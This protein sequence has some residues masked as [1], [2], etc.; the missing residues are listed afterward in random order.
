MKKRLLVFITSLCMIFAYAVPAFAAADKVSD[1]ADVQAAYEAYVAMT[2][3]MYTSGD[4]AAMVAAFNKLDQKSTVIEN[5]DAKS[6]AW[7]T[8]VA[9]KIGEDEFINDVVNL[10]FTMV[11]FEKE[12][13]GEIGL[14]ED[15]KTAPELSKAYD[16]VDMYEALEENKVLM[17][18]LAASIDAADP[19]RKVAVTYEAAEKAVED[20]LVAVSPDVIAVY[21]AY[22]LVSNAVLWADPDDFDEA[23]SEFTKV[24]DTFNN[25]LD[26]DEKA[27]LAELLGANDWKEAYDMILG[28]WKNLNIAAEMIDLYDAFAADPSVANAEAFVEKYDA[29]YNDPNYVDEDLRDLVSESFE[30]IIEEDAGVEDVY[31]NAL[32]IL[33]A[34]EGGNAGGDGEAPEPE[35]NNGKSDSKSPDTGDNM[36]VLPFAVI[37]ALAAAG[38]VAAVRRR[39]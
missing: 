21:D 15:Y 11:V 34:S 12:I 7:Q 9:D 19:A 23:I 6:E 4:Y 2:D 24:L 30:Y 8:V 35:D 39:A 29:I 32:A 3:A 26:D 5:D 17:D 16:L 18:Q 14:I 22:V 13:E 10:A 27:D 33:A 38:A 36:N 1:D 20:A 31:N 28:D 25:E 37:M